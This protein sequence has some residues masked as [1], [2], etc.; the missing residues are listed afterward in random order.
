MAPFGV[1]ADAPALTRT[2]AAATAASAARTIVSARLRGQLRVDRLRPE[3]L[4]VLGGKL[5]QLQLER[6]GEALRG[7]GADLLDGD[8]PAELTRDGREGCVLEAAGGDPLGE[9]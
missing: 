6:L 2:S 8:V 1:V 7:E 5:V 4:G 9:R 3:R